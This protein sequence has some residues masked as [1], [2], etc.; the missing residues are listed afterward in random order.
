MAVW[1]VVN[2]T[3][4]GAGSATMIDVTSISSS[5]DHLYLMGSLRSDKAATTRTNAEIRF[6]GDTGTNYDTVHIYSGGGNVTPTGYKQN[7]VDSF[8]DIE[9]AAASCLAD[10][11]S[12]FEM[13]IY[14]YS[15]TTHMKQCLLLSS[16]PDNDAAEHKGGIKV[17]AGVWSSTAAIDRINMFVGTDNF[18]QYS[19]LTI[20]GINGA[21]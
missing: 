15:N 4:L 8:D 5:Y 16:T 20:Y 3:E 10:T 12:S 13:W 14:N 18:V 9:C 11:F 17:T 7:G 19:S 6:N 2:H 1:N 21:A